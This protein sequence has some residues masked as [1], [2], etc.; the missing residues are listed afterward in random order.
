MP[1]FCAYTVGMKQKQ[2]EQYTIRNVPKALDQAL[3]RQVKASG[4]SLNEVLIESLRRGTGIAGEA[5]AHDHLDFLIGHW[6]DDT[7][8]TEAIAAQ[9][10]IDPELWPC[11]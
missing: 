4:R 11:D 7:A 6:E 8:T 9:R 3:R 5:T 2:A 1:A 10:T